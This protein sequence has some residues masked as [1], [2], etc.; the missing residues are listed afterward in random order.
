MS[1]KQRIHGYDIA[2]ALAVFGMVV[3]NFKT[4]MHAHADGGA[5]WLGLFNLLD[6]RASAIF[7]IL[8][9]VGITLMSNAARLA[10]DA[11]LLRRERISLLKR[12][13]FL[14]VTGLLYI[15]VWPADI[16]H[17]YGVYI[18]LAAV[19][20][21]A[22][23][24]ALLW[25]AIGIALAFPLLF[26]NLDYTSAWNWQTLAYADLWTPAGFARNLLFNGFHPV[27][28]WA[29][30]L[31][32]G[33][34]LGRLPLQQAGL[35]RKVFWGGLATTVVLETLAWALRAEAQR[36]GYAPELVAYLFSTT[37]MPPLPLYFFSAV[38]SSCAVIALCV[39]AG[40]AWRDAPWLR[41]LVRTGQM[42]LTM[43]VAHVVV[44]MGLLEQLGLLNEQTLGFAVASALLFCLAAVL[45]AHLWRGRFKLGPLEWL[46]RKASAS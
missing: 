44:G 37:P 11:A 14:F 18:A 42:A 2:R 39:H 36:R 20:L 40:E 23:N 41:P 43:Y 17:Y 19:L 5:W 21:G 28:P 9:G 12:A 27:L 35:R 46:M 1:E 26:L 29:A 38:G 16:L 10:G 33:L 45:F 31:V 15:A 30:F 4:V 25:S 7:V 34:L 6:G 32:F 8:A 22:S 24:R 13:A 3:V